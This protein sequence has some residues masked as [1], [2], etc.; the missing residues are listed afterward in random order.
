MSHRFGSWV[1]GALVLFVGAC[2]G[3]PAEDPAVTSFTAER[4]VVTVG[5]RARLTA[6]FVGGVGSISSVNGE[7]SSGVLLETEPLAGDTTFTLTVTGADGKKSATASVTVRAVPLPVVTSFSAASPAA[8]RGEAASLTAV[9]SGGTA[10][11]APAVG[12]VVSGVARSTGPL[13]A[14]QTFTLTVTSPSGEVVRATTSVE[15]REAPS[16]TTFTAAKAIVTRGTG[17]TLTATYGGGA[18]VVSGGL[19]A[20]ASGATLPTGPLTQDTTFTLT[21]TGTVGTPATATV[22][23]QVVDPPV[24]QSFTAAASSVTAG[25]STTLTASFTGG[26]GSVDRSIGSAVSGAPLSVSPTQ[27]TT[28][29]LTVTNAAMESATETVTVTVVPAPVIISF[30]SSATDL[31]VG[32]APVLT[33]EFSGGT[34]TI[35]GI[36]SQFGNGQPVASQPLTAPGPRTHT[37]TVTNALGAT[38]TRSLTV[39]AWPFAS[40]SNFAA[41]PAVV[42]VGGTVTFTGTF[43]GAGS[44]DQGVG[45][46]TSPLSKATTVTSTTTYALTVTNPAG[47]SL[48]RAVM[49]TAVP[50]PTIT[51]FTA[52]AANVNVGAQPSLTATFTGGTA[53]ISQGVGAAVSGTPVSAPA[54]TTAGPVTY[55]LTV[56]NAAGAQATQSVTV[57]AWAPPSIASFT[58]TPSHVTQGTSTVLSGTFSGGTG[59]LSLGG[60]VVSPFMR[61]QVLSANTT[62]TL[63][64]TSPTGSTATASVAVT[65][66]PPPV[67]TSFTGRQLPSGDAGVTV[68]VPLGSSVGLTSVFSSG[69]GRVSWPTGASTVAS[70]VELVRGPLSNDTLFTLSVTNDAGTAVTRT[71]PVEVDHLMYLAGTAGNMGGPGLVS[72]YPSHLKQP[73]PSLRRIYIAN[74]NWPT[75]LAYEPAAGAAAP[76][77][78]V[79]CR[80][81]FTQTSQIVR[82]ENPQSITSTPSTPAPSTITPIAG[83]NTLMTAPHS[84]VL[85]GNELVVLNQ[86]SATVRASIQVFSKSLGGN[87]APVRAI[88]PPSSGDL[89]QLGQTSQVFAYQN[90]LYVTS[91]T[92]SG[93]GTQGVL[94][95]PLNWS[96]TNIAPTRTLVH[97]S[98]TDVRGVFVDA[99]GIFVGTTTGTHRFALGASGTTAPLQTSS[100]TVFQQLTRFDDTLYSGYRWGLTRQPVSLMGQAVNVGSLAMDYDTP[101]ATVIDPAY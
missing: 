3:A 1:L 96:G 59:S 90:E 33:A 27:T 91:N 40:I 41:S 98:L 72:V 85:V 14:T 24:I 8:A 38:V 77:L 19:G 64:V 78:W 62:I 2:G 21:V 50:P 82:L 92:M 12:A 16:I 42:T 57:T 31:T 100:A 95:Y 6:V 7:V 10:D 55:V 81:I 52:A 32:S 70:G 83:T 15:V 45:M 20:L 25:T 28:W 79:A 37:L 97:P 48:T 11:V 4:E 46:V 71:V 67:I 88:L 5:Q 94:V 80:P 23:V 69:A 39:T 51:S 76:A 13:M 84:M 99:D 68:T 18:G 43:V 87:V 47:D 63:T 29:T 93:V 36:S 9:F 73:G 30:T 58:A 89:T 35:T 74:C 101:A 61:S 49:V 75:G 44:I 60:A 66:T 65:T 56:T 26:T 86:A 17:T 53:T 54:L 22:S 34:A